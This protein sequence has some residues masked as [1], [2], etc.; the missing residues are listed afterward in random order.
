MPEDDGALV[1]ATGEVLDL[2]T[3]EPEASA[4]GTIPA[5][6]LPSRVLASGAGGSGTVVSE[7][8]VPAKVTSEKVTSEKVTSGAASSDGMRPAADLWVDDDP[9]VAQFF[10][11]PPPEYP[12]WLGAEADSG[13]PA[14]PGSDGS[15]AEEAPGPHEGAAG[16]DATASRSG[17]SR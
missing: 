8:V 10:A 15:A 9:V 13:S 5:D 6:V 1:D 14:D 16:P 4:T 2:R 7:R 17:H 3:P 11:S 12:L